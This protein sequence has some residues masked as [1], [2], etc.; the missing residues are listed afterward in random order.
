MSVKQSTEASRS[1]V[2]ADLSKGLTL[3]VLLVIVAATAK[4]GSPSY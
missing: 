2:A 4:L 3:G 1:E